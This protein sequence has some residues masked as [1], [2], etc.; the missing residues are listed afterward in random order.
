[1]QWNVSCVR[2]LQTFPE[3]LTLAFHSQTA[4][5]KEHMFPNWMRPMVGVVRVD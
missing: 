2:D 4:S 5:V 1:M 3:V